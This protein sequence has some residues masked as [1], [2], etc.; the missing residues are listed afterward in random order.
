MIET[1]GVLL[2]GG[3]GRRLGLGVPKAL[4]EVS[5]MTLLDRAVATLAAVSDR[6]VVAAPPGL[7]LPLPAGVARV[8]DR[9]GVSGP[10]AGALAGLASGRFARALLLGVD[11]PCVTPALLRELL[12]RLAG[13][14][15]VIP[16]PGGRLQPLVAAYGPGAPAQLEREARAADATITRAVATLTGLTLGDAALDTFPGGR[17]SLFNVN[18]PAQLAEAERRLASTTPAAGAR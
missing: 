9:P 8:A 17:A 11:F 4:V 14:D 16:A 5:G 10:L 6:V 1:L 7:D 2:A 15:A 12:A 18:T 3:E 13:H